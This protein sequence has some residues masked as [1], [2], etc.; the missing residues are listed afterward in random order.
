M[1]KTIHSLDG[2]DFWMYLWEN[3]AMK[4]PMDIF[5]YMIMGLRQSKTIVATLWSW[6]ATSGLI[7][8]ANICDRNQEPC[9]PIIED[10]K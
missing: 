10:S 9:F 2:Q 6:V 3:C 1:T 4:V 8:T 5:E 7:W